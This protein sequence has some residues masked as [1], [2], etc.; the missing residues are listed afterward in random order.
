[1]QVDLKLLNKNEI[2]H[3]S[4]NIPDHPTNTINKH[5]KHFSA[6]TCKPNNKNMHIQ[7]KSKNDK[8]LKVTLKNPIVHINNRQRGLLYETTV[9]Q[10]ADDPKSSISAGLFI[11]ALFS[12]T[13]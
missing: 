5:K 12:L 4:K 11:Q 2:W 1:M 3:P 7:R 10:A 6:K 13:A 9:S 8:L